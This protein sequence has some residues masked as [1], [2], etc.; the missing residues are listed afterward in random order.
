[1]WERRILFGNLGGFKEL[2]DPQIKRISADF[3]FIDF[4]T[5]WVRNTYLGAPNF[6]RQSR[7]L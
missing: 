3:I 1:M 2:L 5:W 7:R 6:I 4:V